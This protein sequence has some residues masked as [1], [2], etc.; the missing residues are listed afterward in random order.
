MKHVRQFT[1]SQKKGSWW[2][3]VGVGKA[4]SVHL[5]ELVVIGEKGLCYRGNHGK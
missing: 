1:N 3:L 4:P 5:V 2:E